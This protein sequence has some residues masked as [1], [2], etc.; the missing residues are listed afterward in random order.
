MPIDIKDFENSDEDFFRGEYALE[1]QKVA[2]FLAYNPEKAY[3]RQEIQSTIELSTIGLLATLSRL[4]HEGLVRNK[5]QY[6]AIADDIDSVDDIPDSLP[7]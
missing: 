6:W 4:E 7:F 5:G 3:S 1:S 2:E